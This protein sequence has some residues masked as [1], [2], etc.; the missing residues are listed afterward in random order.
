MFILF[1]LNHFIL[2]VFGGDKK[3]K[4]GSKTMHSEEVFISPR[5]SG[6]LLIGKS[7]TSMRL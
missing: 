7:K 6:L 1:I 4:S 3:K 2:D 5:N